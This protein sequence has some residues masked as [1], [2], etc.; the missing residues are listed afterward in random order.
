MLEFYQS[1]VISSYLIKENEQYNISIDSIGNN[2]KRY[3]SY[4]EIYFLLNNN[5][6]TECKCY[7]K[8]IEL[9]LIEYYYKF[10]DYFQIKQIVTNEEIELEIYIDTSKDLNPKKSPAFNSIFKDKYK[11]DSLIDIMD[12]KRLS[13]YST[14]PQTNQE[15]NFSDLHLYE[16]QKKN[17]QKMLNIENDNLV[18]SPYIECN[19]LGKKEMVC[20]SDN[21]DLIEITT[22][23]GVLADEMGLGKTISMLGL[24]HYNPDQLNLEICENK[25]YTKCT[26][27]IVPSHLSKQWVDEVKKYMPEKKIITMY[28]KAN[29]KKVTYGDII[30]CDILII[31]QQ[32]L[33]NFNYYVRLNFEYVTPS[34]YNTR[35]NN[36]RNKKLQKMLDEWLDDG[37]NMVTDNLRIITQPMFEHFYFHRIVIDEG[38]EIFDNYSSAYNLS[39][40][41]QLLL[42]NSLSSHYKWFVSGTP[43]ASITG[44]NNI[45]KY[46]NVQMNN[47]NAEL[48]NNGFFDYNLSSFNN[49]YF[50]KT[51]F[52]KLIVRSTKED[53]ENELNIPGYDEEVLFVKLTD[54]EKTFYNSYSNY[55]SITLQQI[56]C[57]PLIVDKFR[58]M[59]GGE[60]GDINNIQ[61]KMLQ[62]NKDI[63]EKYTDK[64]E[65]LDPLATEY[66]MLKK[67]YTTILN[68]AKFLVRSLEKVSSDENIKEED[69]SICY[70]TIDEPTM[71]EC[72][73][74][75]CK[76]CIELALDY[77]SNCP[78]CRKSI[79]KSKVYKITKKE[80]KEKTKNDP[81]I[82]KY[83]TKLA[84]LIKTMKKITKS[85]K[86]KVIIFSQWDNMLSMIGKT[87]SEN[88]ITNTF[89]KGSVYQRNNAISKF[90]TGK[91]SR[92]KKAESNVIM[93][94]LE[95]SASGT[96]LTE[97]THIIFIEPI[98]K[99]KKAR[100]AIEGQA[101]GRVCRIG[102]DEKVK[103][104]RIIT[105]ETIEEDIYKN[106]IVS[107]D[108]N[109]IVL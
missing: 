4:T 28:T 87:L 102:K 55:D 60:I 73:H 12:V 44:L 69:C 61:E 76:G 3:N 57:H 72:G 34:M 71:T 1:I 41:L 24:I 49:K 46:L 94:S 70:D 62:Y 7:D 59:V 33:L 52:E 78:S 40:Y 38:H 53:V 97:A 77:Q 109:N 54:N 64:L 25:L 63:I 108:E 84:T 103:I 83:G 105:E 81:L 104:M 6:I 68:E 92:G 96:N 20:V 8:I 93:L 99:N 37:N 2:R 45:M 47:T 30:D 101:I 56:C 11:I 17:I 10:T 31:S 29:H 88:G 32:F 91:T 9:I 67:K 100:T 23:G 95:N 86:N 98:N 16:Y 27:I 51:F 82:L 79:N 50:I 42:N 58:N 5:F 18:L 66:G 36:K 15:Y 74:I 65:E 80:K 35:T 48:S 39:N 43:F 19:V 106:K 85:S 26:V 14:L 21:N 90:K 13:Y 107:S 89:I 22:K 75:F